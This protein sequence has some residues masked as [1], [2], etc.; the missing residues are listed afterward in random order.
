MPAAP[1]QGPSKAA[2]VDEFGRVTCED[3][4]ARTDVFAAEIMSELPEKGLIVIYP[5]A[6]RPE[7]AAKRF[8]LVSSTLQLRGL[9]QD[10]YAFYKGKPVS[11]GDIRTQFWKLPHGA[12]STG[13]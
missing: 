10:G 12:R 4:I 5:P 3:L 9:E 6:M 13:Y 1:A 11:N 7:L 2:L 8:S